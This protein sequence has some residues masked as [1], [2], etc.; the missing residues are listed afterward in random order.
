M[1]SRQVSKFQR[2]A[3]VRSALKLY[4]KGQSSVSAIKVLGLAW[5]SFLTAAGPAMA[6]HAMGKSTPSSFFEGF[7]S[8]LAHPMIG[9]DHLAFVVAIGLISAGRARGALIP[10]AF[11]LTAL[12][13]TGVHLLIDLPAVEIAIATSVIAVGLLLL[14]RKRFG[15][16]ALAALATLAGLFHGYAYGE[17]IIGAETTPLL[18]YL[19]GFT[20]MQFVIAM[21]AQKL[22]NLLIQARKHSPNL[23]RIAGCG[24]SVVGATF[25]IKAMGS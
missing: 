10:G 12:A 16:N 5:I 3:P 20:L 1:K 11:L 8:G 25:L 17:S 15:L 14:S 7:V 4:H 18:A 13:G 6:H 22:G 21:L 2:S 9:L 23:L 19:L 24:I